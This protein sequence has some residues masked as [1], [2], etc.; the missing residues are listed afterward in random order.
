MAV[1]ENAP[2]QNVRRQGEPIVPYQ[3]P[4]TRRQQRRQQSI[5]PT[6][7]ERNEQLRADNNNAEVVYMQEPE[8]GRRNGE[9]SRTSNQEH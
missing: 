7:E 3:R 1:E 5:N 8:S 6:V 4:A 2:Q 9:S